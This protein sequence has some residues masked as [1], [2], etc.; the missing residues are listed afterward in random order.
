MSKMRWSSLALALCASLAFA[1]EPSPINPEH[2]LRVAE[3]KAERDLAAWYIA[4]PTAALYHTNAAA[5]TKLSDC[6]LWIQ[7][8]SVKQKIKEKAEKDAREVK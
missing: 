5:I 8:E 3:R 7:A 1:G 4:N 2:T 6:I